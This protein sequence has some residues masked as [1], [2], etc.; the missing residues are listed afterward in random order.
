MCRIEAS[1]NRQS[2]GNGSDD[3]KIKEDDQDYDLKEKLLPPPQIPSGTQP[4]ENI[5]E[6]AEISSSM[7]T[8]VKLK[9]KKSKSKSSR[10]K[11]RA[12]GSDHSDRAGKLLDY[13]VK[14][15][16]REVEFADREV[17]TEG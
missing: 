17:K 15:V 10:T 13:K 11:L 9:T 14:F 1:S 16:D 3:E 5:T 7:N 8:S 4:N 2:F 12:P 6:K